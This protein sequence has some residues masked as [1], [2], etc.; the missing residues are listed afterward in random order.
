M[1]SQGNRIGEYKGPE[2]QASP[3]APGAERRPVETV[4]RE[5]RSPTWGPFAAP[6]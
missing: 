3:V 4:T 1:K 5:G 2:A 6:V